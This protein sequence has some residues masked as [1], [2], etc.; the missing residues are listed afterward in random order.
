MKHYRWRIILS[1]SNLLLAGLLFSLGQHEFKS[2]ARSPGA[3][4]EGAVGYV[5][6]AQQVSYCWN[7]PSLVLTAPLRNRLTGHVVL[8]GSW[9]TYGDIEYGI[10]VFLFWWLVG[11]ELDWVRANRVSQWSRLIKMVGYVLGVGFSL[12]LLYAGASGLAGTFSGPHA[13]VVSM[14][15]WGLILLYYFGRKLKGTWH[16][17]S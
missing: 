6:T 14:L 2:L 11:L 13:I 9:V 5:P 3:F 7:T 1:V 8:F 15:L 12:L 16:P 17:T 4:Y 10:A